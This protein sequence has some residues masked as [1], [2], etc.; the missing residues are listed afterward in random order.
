MGIKRQYCPYPSRRAEHRL[1]HLLMTAVETVK[2]TNG[3]GNRLV[4]LLER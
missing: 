3:N 2:I 1:E 4:D